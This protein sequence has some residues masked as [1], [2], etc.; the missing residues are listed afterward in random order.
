MAKWATILTL[1]GVAALTA[2]FGTARGSIPFFPQAGERRPA[3]V[4]VPVSAAVVTRADVPVSLAGLGTVQAFNSVLVKSRIDGQIV[5]VDFVEGEDVRA[6]DV[7][8]EIDP[9]PFEASLSQA[10]ANKAKDEAQLANARLDLDRLSRLITTSA[11]SRQQLD[12]ARA[13]WPA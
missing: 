13:G 7:L 8:V 3:P 9:R 1:L 6:G 4:P 5:K 12:T 11:I 10:Q 2:Y